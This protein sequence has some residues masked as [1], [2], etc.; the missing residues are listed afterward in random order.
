M[1]ARSRRNLPGG[2]LRRGVDSI[3]SFKRV[4][5]K[6]HVNRKKEDKKMLGEKIPNQKQARRTKRRS[7]VSRKVRRVLKAPFYNWTVELFEDQ[8]GKKVC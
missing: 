7:S 8:R 2:L 3:G 5:N 4:L 6:L 1:M